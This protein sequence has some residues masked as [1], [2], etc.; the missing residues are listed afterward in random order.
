M[1]CLKLYDSF[2]K[3]DTKNNMPYLRILAEKDPERKEMLCILG[4]QDAQHLS[5]DTVTHSNAMTGERFLASVP[6]LHHPATSCIA[7]QHTATHLGG[8]NAR[9]HNKHTETHRNTPQRT[10][11]HRNTP[12]HTSVAGILVPTA[13]PPLRLNCTL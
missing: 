11:I 9:A 13:R 1:A 4:T 12:Q 6:G 10:A 2:H 8:G 7:M 3:R 5:R